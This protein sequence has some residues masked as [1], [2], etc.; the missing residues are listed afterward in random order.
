MKSYRTP[1]NAPQWLCHNVLISLDARKGI[2][3]GSPALWADLFDQLDL[4]LGERVLQVGAGTGYYTAILA[5]LVGRRGRV[6]AIE[7]DKRLAVRART[8]LTVWPQVNVV[9]GDASTS[10]AGEVDVVVAHAGGTHPAALWLERRG[11]AGTFAH[12]FGYE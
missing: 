7:F 5:A 11:T 9:C 3:N 4:K 1:D 12:A 8:N 2:N 10:D 6:H